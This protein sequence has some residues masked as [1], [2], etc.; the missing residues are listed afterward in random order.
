[1]RTEYLEFL[2]EISKTKSMSLA[3]KN[4]YISP[5]GISSAVSKLENELGVCLVNRTYSGVQLTE[6]GEK[7]VVL[8]S[9]LLEEIK[10][11]KSEQIDESPET[12]LEGT[13]SIATPPLF[14]PIIL[15]KTVPIFKSK[16]PRVKITIKEMDSYDVL[17]AVAR[18]DSNL[19][20]VMLVKSY[21]KTI[22]TNLNIKEDL[23]IAELFCDSLYA[24]VGKSSPLAN[25]D[26]ITI[27][28]VLQYPLA[29]FY[30]GKSIIQY[31]ETFSHL[32]GKP[33]VAIESES[34]YPC[35]LSVEEGLAVGFASGYAVRNHLADKMISIPI[36]DT[37][38]LSFGWVRNEKNELSSFSHDFIKIIKSNCL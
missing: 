36:S 1:M 19:G 7:L 22:L 26:S 18:G 13:L 12:E 2:V 24:N 14:C 37:I 20:L 3:A 9:S 28:E 27:K 38:E 30:H 16:Y 8:A 35:E 23:K 34:K 10:E 31:L 17:L 32:Y 21:I 11:I 29:V 4:L 6:A 25:K 33:Q 15:A 5:Q